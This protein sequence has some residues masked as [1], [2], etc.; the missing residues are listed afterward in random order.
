[1]ATLTVQSVVRGGLEATTSAAAAGG[2]EYVNTGKQ[3]AEFTNASGSS[4]TVTIV[5][6][7]TIDGLAVAN[8]T[9]IVEAGES[10][11]IGPFPTAQYNDANS[12]VQFTYSDVT[13]F[14][15]GVFQ[16]N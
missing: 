8:R 12:K 4:I 15:V 14:T 5:L 3:W 7:Q 10:R 6:Q 13:T 2:D 1:M 16:L 11:K 9:V